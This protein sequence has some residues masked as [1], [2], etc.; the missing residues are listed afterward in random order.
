MGKLQANQ[1]KEIRKDFTILLFLQL[2]ENREPHGEAL[3]GQKA[4]GEGQEPT[5]CFL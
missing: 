2:P 3:D 4:E 5:M 1:G